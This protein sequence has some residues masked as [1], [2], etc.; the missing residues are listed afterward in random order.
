MDSATWHFCSLQMAFLFCFVYL[1][2]SILYFSLV[3]RRK[4]SFLSFL[5]ISHNDSALCFSKNSNL[6][7][8][9]SIA[10]SQY[11]V[12]LFFLIIK[13]GKIII[14]GNQGRK[15]K[16]KKQCLIRGHFCTGHARTF[17]E[18]K[19]IDIKIDGFLYAK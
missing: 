1:S 3:I 12:R 11:S 6:D 15:S 13:V 19:M 2:P 16:K 18:R 8:E 9:G 17:A 10:K 5:A 14:K 7:W 4:L